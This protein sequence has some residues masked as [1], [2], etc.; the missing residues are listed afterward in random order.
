MFSWE[1]FQF[2]FRNQFGGYF[3]VAVLL[4]LIQWFCTWLRKAAWFTEVSFLVRLIP[5]PTSHPFSFLWLCPH[6]SQKWILCPSFFLQPTHRTSQVLFWF[7]S[8]SFLSQ[9]SACLM[10]RSA[11]RPS[12]LSCPFWRHISSLQ[13]LSLSSWCLI[14]RWHHTLVKSLALGGC[15]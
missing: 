13:S 11:S 6:T 12:A 4:D 1:N 3:Q 9:V 14:W 7:A 2:I 10:S 15:L 8:S 5:W